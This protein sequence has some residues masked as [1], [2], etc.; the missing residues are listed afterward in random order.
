MID[1]KSQRSRKK[2]RKEVEWAPFRQSE[3]IWSPEEKWREERL[4]GH[5]KVDEGQRKRLRQTQHRKQ[6]RKTI[7]TRNK[8]LGVEEIEK[9][10]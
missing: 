1:S 4:P 7:R 10:L 5:I 3:T 6:S 2:E 9:D 8:W